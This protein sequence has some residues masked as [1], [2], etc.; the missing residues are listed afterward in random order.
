[1][2]TLSANLLLAQLTPAQMQ[3]IKEQN[4]LV[5]EWNTPYQTPPF[6]KIKTK[7]YKPAIQY[8]LEKAKEDINK[9][10]SNTQEPNF[11][12]TIEALDRSGRLLSRTLGVFYNINEANTSKE[13]QEV[14]EQMA[15]ELT[16]YSNDLNMN[17]LLFAKVKAVYDKRDDIPLTTEQ[18]TLLDKTYRSF[19]DNG[20]L[21]QGKDKEEYRKVTEELSLLTLKFQKNDLEDQNA[22]QLLITNKKDLKGMPQYAID[23]AKDAAKEKGKKG[24]LFTLDYPSFLAF[25]T[26]NDNRELRKQMWIAFNKQGNQDNANDNKEVARQIANSRLRLAQLLGYNSF[27]QYELSDKMAQ[28]PEKVNAFLDELMKA[29]LPFAQ[30]DL[31]EVTDYA[32]SKGFTDT[33]QRWDFGY[34]SEKLKQEKYSISPED[35]KPYFQLEN[36]KQGIFMLADTL[37]GLQFKENTTIQKYHPDV[38][39]YEVWDKNTNKFMAVLYMDFFPRT[40]KR[41]GAWMTNFREQYVD[42]NGQDIRPLIQL[43]TN[44]T[45][46]TSK[47]PSLLTFDEFNT[48]LHEF[49]HCLHGMLSECNYSSISGTNVYH[50]FVEMP[51]QIME[52]FATQKQFLDIFAKNYKTGEKIPQSLIEKI[53]KSEQYNAGYLSLRQLFFGLLDMRYH[54]ITKPLTGDIESIEREISSVAELLPPVKG[55]IMTTQFGHIFS[56]GY[57]AGYYGYKWAEVIDADAFS[58]FEAKGIFNK[59]VSNS[60]RKNILSQGGKKNP[61]ELYKAFRGQEPTNKALLKRCGFIK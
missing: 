8:S 40:S 35:T 13:L 61:M 4:P 19:V 42:E 39:V 56:N 11:Q 26:Y 47:T 1:M 55:C 36:V 33:I 22:Y 43:V 46:P 9:I 10:I 59:E 17:P 51:S 6:D 45:K 14:A 5:Q 23:A 53:K 50:D 38:K 30:K 18:R 41:S 12:N 21:L 58:V 7:D 34:W 60:F 20:A 37:Y 52:N 28:S 15:P 29:S 54:N 25:M 27:A 24:Y 57:A 2:M 16:A 31:K 3:S 32:I 49:G 44:F 48:L